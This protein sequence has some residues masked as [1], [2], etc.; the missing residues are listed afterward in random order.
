MPSMLFPGRFASLERI[1][2]FF[3]DAAH[4]AGLDETAIHSIELAADEA[5]A[6]I[7]DHAYGGEDLGD[8]E[9]TWSLEPTR[10]VMTLHDHGTPFEPELIAAPDTKSK[11]TERKPR[12]LGLYFMR[13]LMDE[14]RFEFNGEEGNLLTMIKNRPTPP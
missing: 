6:N 9:C 2:A 14:V 1:R 10:L 11:I 13:R 3:A 8:I 4:Q 12:G 5:A 7:I